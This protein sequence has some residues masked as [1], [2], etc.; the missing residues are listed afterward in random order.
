MRFPR[1]EH[2]KGIEN[3]LATVNF[4]SMDVN[5]PNPLMIIISG[6]SGVGKDA[7][8]Q[9]LKQRNLPLHFVVTATSRAPRENE[10]E[11]V[12]YFFVTKEQFRQMI[13][14]DE[15]IEYALVYQDYKGIPKEQVRKAL[16]SGRDVILRVDVQG[17]E[18]LRDLFPE[19]VL[20]FVVPQDEDEWRNRLLN[21]KSETEESFQL[22]VKTAE[23]EM[24]KLGI[25]DY[26]V[27]NAQDRL[28]EAV[29]TIIAIVDAEH[30]RVEP[31]KIKV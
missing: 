10:V 31:R 24:Q 7:I 27:V 22:R 4:L 23:M 2:Q 14:H 29:N 28:E 21:R 6:P 20:I 18:R 26:V 11:G 5:R 13:N 8:L 17:A 25:F 3:S 16:E 1:D 9:S 12:D 15:L 19:A 30:H